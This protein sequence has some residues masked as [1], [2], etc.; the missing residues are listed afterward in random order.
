[1]FGKMLQS[2]SVLLGS[3]VLSTTAAALIATGSGGCVD[4]QQQVTSCSAGGG[5]GGGG[6][7]DSEPSTLDR[8]VITG[9]SQAQY[10]FEQWALRETLSNLYPRLDRLDLPEE[11]RGPVTNLAAGN[12]Q[13]G[14]AT[15]TANDPNAKNSTT[16]NPVIIATGEK[17]LPQRDFA[18]GGSAGFVMSRTYR[19]NSLASL[20]APSFGANWAS[21]LDFG[22][23]IAARPKVRGL[24]TA[25]TLITLVKGDG[26]RITFTRVEG[27]SVVGESD[28]NYAAVGND[29]YGEIY[30]DTATG[31][32]DW[33]GGT[34]NAQFAN[35][36]RIQYY[37]STNG[38]MSVDFGYDASSRLATITLNSSRTIS[39]GY[40]SNNLVS[41]VTVPGIGSWTYLYDSSLRLA[42]VQSPGSNPT[43]T[44]YHY[45]NASLPSAITGFSVNGIR[46]TR[47]DYYADGRVSS[48]GSSDNETRDSFVYGA[49]YTKVT[50]AYGLEVTYNY[51]TI[52][53]AKYLSSTSAPA[54]TG[55]P[56]SNASYTY[57]ANGNVKTVTDAQGVVTSFTYNAAGNVT[58]KDEAYGT[59]N[60]R[61]TTMVW[62][63]HGLLRE[64][65]LINSA[66]ATVNLQTFNYYT[67]GV[68]IGTAQSVVEQ[69]I[70]TGVSRTISYAYFHDTSGKL[71]RVEIT[72]QGLGTEAF[73]Y[74]T[75]GD[76]VQ[77]WN[78]LGQTTNYGG[79]NGLGQF[80]YVTTPD[81]LSTS[82]V[83]DG[84][85]RMSSATVITPSGNRTT[86]Y[87]WTPDGLISQVTSPAGLVTTYAYTPSA[88]RLYQ[89]A[90]NSGRVMNYS[91]SGR[92]FSA[93]IPRR[94]PDLSGSFPVG[95]VAGNISSTYE[96]NSLGAP[97]K[98][99]AADGVTVKGTTSYFPSGNVQSVTDS[100]GNQASQT[101][102][103]LGRARTSTATDGG[104]IYT[105][106]DL[107]DQVTQVTDPNGR[108]T[109]YSTDTLGRPLS[110]SS[111]STGT[112]TLT[113]ALWGG[114]VTAESRANGTTISYGRDA[115]FRPTSRSGGG[116]AE[117]FTYDTCANGT[118]R[119]CS[120]SDSS[121][122][123]TFSYDGSGNLV[124]KV[125]SVGGVNYTLAWTYDSLSRPVTLTYPNG[126]VLTYQYDTVGR[127]YSILSN[128][129]STVLDNL[130]YGE[131]GLFAWRWGNGVVGGITTDADGRLIALESRG[132]QSL[133]FSYTGNDLVQSI[134]DGA[135]PGLNSTF[136]WDGSGRLKQVTRANGDNQ[137]V[138]YD[139]AGNR[140]G[141]TRAGVAN[142]YQY[143]ASGR[144]W[145]T[146]VGSR[147]YSWDGYGQ[148]I[149]D[150]IRSFG[151]DGFGRLASA[152]G[153]TYSYNAFNQRVRK[154]GGTGVNDFVYGPAGELL[155][156]SQSGTAYIYVGGTLIAMS[157]SSQ[158]FAVHTDQVG[159]PEAV[160]NG[161]RQ[162]AWRAQNA[163]WDRQIA[164]DS[165]GGLNIGFPGQY[166]D[167]ET[168]FW[169]NWNRYY[170]SSTGRYT[171]S[172]PIG[173]AGGVN[174]YS[175]VKGNP[176]SAY[177]PT[178]LAQC[179]VDDMTKLAQQ[180]NP[181][182]KIDKP[183][184]EN[185]PP[186]YAGYTP[187][188]P[189]ATPQVSASVYA[190]TLNSSQRIDLYNT[191][192]HENVHANLQSFFSRFRGGLDLDWHDKLENEAYRIGN[193]RAARDSKKIKATGGGSCVCKK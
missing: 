21:S 181:D 26:T 58:R 152:A 3:C 66:G 168:G 81:G 116:L 79:H 167:V 171:Q 88:N 29:S 133:G 159:R 188:V 145:L 104:T 23:L 60:V 118:G 111:P 51:Q 68:D 48:S 10:N 77:T 30:Y 17:I 120:M 115:L 166:Y 85:G 149:S 40:N 100:V 75:A 130:L 176:V 143:T 84:Q 114:V 153:T 127:L 11:A 136:G 91:R 112:T 34:F 148:M 89:V 73:V 16:S 55:C 94:V 9:K 28:G 33:V 56:A 46:K 92:L 125:Q 126:L 131:S 44:T 18:I 109:T 129:W 142:S 93:T 163:A 22:R 169:Q 32:A 19:A 57:D 137:T 5:G 36:G 123:T 134:S 128:Q 147:G 190:G 95:T 27:P 87:A 113:P 189:F 62:D 135:N 182:L 15:C 150:G 107:M 158:M 83:Y 74:N 155:Y 24:W 183:T 165:I 49:T 43:S 121:G 12:T 175:Y 41:Q 13:P 37:T 35:G 193:S 14:T 61:T 47:Y 90:D 2:A 117:T 65:R 141:H 99:Y 39:V 4:A 69:D 184:M 86:S 160:T 144:D 139:V 76:L 53:G 132:I 54:G 178:G 179:D 38:R 101:Y 177:D 140:T 59:V 172:D 52:N 162:V 192:I 110:M 164:A 122:S 96:V 151:W 98:V 180:L 138:T 173:L 20:Y 157:R 170:D 82:Y 105:D 187:L 124:Q 71:I 72:R 50:N 146:Q 42:S 67:S 70:A 31:I 106:Y 80:G 97:W 7:A 185:L 161:S 191:I 63:S 156:E 174:T 8:V 119:L 103:E 186:D 1:M 64:R 108:A 78:A 154:S 6:S 102:D 45:E 25:P